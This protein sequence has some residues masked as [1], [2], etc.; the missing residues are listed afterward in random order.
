MPPS[1]DDSFAPHDAASEHS[2]LSKTVLEPGVTEEEAIEF[3][4]EPFP[5][6]PVFGDKYEERAY[7]KK[8]LTIAFRIFSKFGFDEGVAGHITLRVS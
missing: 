3:T 8:R 5:E 2:R 7:Q 1:R 6:P 4:S